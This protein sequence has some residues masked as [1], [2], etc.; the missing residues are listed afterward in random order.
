[1]LTLATQ[2]YSG[3]TRPISAVQDWPETEAE[4][5]GFPFHWRFEEPWGIFAV[6]NRRNPSL[7]RGL[8]VAFAICVIGPP[9]AVVL[10]NV[11]KKNEAKI[12]AWL[13]WRRAERATEAGS[14]VDVIG[15]AS[16]GYGGAMAPPDDTESEMSREQTDNMRIESWGPEADAET[17][18][19]YQ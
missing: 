19:A 14:D 16:P 1:V 8:M 15:G 2:M 7:A 9:L 18:A 13:P 6:R 3:D 12:L 11:L 10:Y 4:D 5:P 17:P